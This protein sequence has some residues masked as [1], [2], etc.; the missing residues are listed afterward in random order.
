ML[1][2]GGWAKRVV[3]FLGMEWSFCQKI[4]KLYLRAVNASEPGRLSITFDTATLPGS[5]QLGIDNID[6]T[7]VVNGIFGDK[8]FEFYVL[9]YFSYSP[10]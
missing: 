9:R 3:Q 8:F 10:L 2:V 4:P 7:E 1:V 6:V 5:H